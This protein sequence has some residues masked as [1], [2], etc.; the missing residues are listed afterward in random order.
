MQGQAVWEQW[1]YFWSDVEPGI[2][3]SAGDRAEQSTSLR[4]S[5]AQWS[6]KYLLDDSWKISFSFAYQISHLLQLLPN[7]IFIL[8]SKLLLCLSFQK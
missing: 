5:T 7:N 6:P 2:R 3:T 1:H 8:L 4:I